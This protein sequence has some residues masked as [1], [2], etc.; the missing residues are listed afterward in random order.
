MTVHPE[1][2]LFSPYAQPANAASP[3][4]PRRTIRLVLYGKLFALDLCALVAGPLLAS[5]VLSRLGLNSGDFLPSGAVLLVYLV[6]AMA[7]GGYSQTTVSSAIDGVRSGILSLLTAVFIVLVVAFFLKSGEDIS[8]LNFAAA[9]FATAALLVAGR[10]VFPRHARRFSGGHL[11]NE[12]IIVDGKTNTLPREGAVIID[13]KRANL[14]PDLN[15]PAMLDA[16][17]TMVRPFDRVL[18]DCL[19]EHR[20]GWALLLKGANVQGELIIEQANEIGA[21]AMGSF[22]GQDTLLV[23]RQALSLPNRLQ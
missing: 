8:R 12:L 19:P 20:R 21:I 6:N 10:A 2:D 9:S 22:H 16:F 23:S 17:G 3:G 15:D 4:L 5:W 18:V 11:M 7:R 14:R 1:Q 13:A